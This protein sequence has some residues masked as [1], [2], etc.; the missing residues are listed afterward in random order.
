MLTTV[1]DSGI[2][3]LPAA[4]APDFSAETTEYVNEADVEFVGTN[5]GGA[6]S[7]YR[8]SWGDGGEDTTGSGEG[9]ITSHF[10]AGQGE[11]TVSYTLYNAAGSAAQTKTDYIT[12]T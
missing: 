4:P 9:A 3:S 7:S 12:V 5:S 8:W 2:V 1:M 6:A 11:Y 10:Y